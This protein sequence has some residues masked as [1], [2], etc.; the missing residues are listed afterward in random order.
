MVLLAS[1][2][3]AVQH[4]APCLMSLYGYVERTGHFEKVNHRYSTRA[5]ALTRACFV[6]THSR[7]PS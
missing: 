2:D 6:F 1:L 5:R 7:R 4:L 3:I